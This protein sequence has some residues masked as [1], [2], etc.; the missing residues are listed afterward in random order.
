MYATTRRKR[1]NDIYFN[2]CISCTV[3]NCIYHNKENYCTLGKIMVSNN[4]KGK[5]N[6]AS[7]KMDK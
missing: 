7:F 1:M 5:A 4:P 3:E 6:C 2:Q